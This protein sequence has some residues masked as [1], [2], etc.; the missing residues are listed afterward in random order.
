MA[1]PDKAEAVKDIAGR[2]KAAEAALL[3][4]YR[5]LRVGEI[6]EV[7]N[8]VRAADADYKVLKNTLAR[9]AVREVGLDELVG[10]LEGPTAVAFCRGDAAAV[11]K[12]LDE[13][14]K[15]FPVLVIKGGVLAGKIIGADEARRLAKLEPRDVQ[16][17]MI[18]TMMNAPLQQTANVLSALL[19]DLGSML[20][21]VAAQKA[22]EEVPPE[23]AGD[24]AVP[25]EQPSAET[26]ES[27][28][29]GTD[30]AA[31]GEDGQDADG[32]AA[33]TLGG[34]V[35]GGEEAAEQAKDEAEEAAEGGE[36]AA[37][38]AKD[39]A[40]EAAEGGDEAAEQAKEE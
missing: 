2:F 39:E 20:A 15:K 11:A 8:A 14:A 26:I 37:E 12:A 5:G 21:Q 31:G 35:P 27:E 10:M 3:T 19:R 16:L 33:T 18:V 25:E 1:R 38:Q 7:R 32:G 9:I 17:A 22:E 23:E 24:E 28:A 4:D 30:T 29:E 34:A 40:E 36:E 13:A 6:A